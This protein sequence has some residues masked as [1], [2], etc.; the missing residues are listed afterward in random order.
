[1]VRREFDE[2]H[3]SN[4]DFEG[5]MI[6]TFVYLEEAVHDPFPLIRCALER[7]CGAPPFQI[8]ASSM[9]W[10]SWCLTIQTIASMW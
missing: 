7:V 9:V 4:D 1:M 5:S 8:K 3:V 10:A 2:V 6:F